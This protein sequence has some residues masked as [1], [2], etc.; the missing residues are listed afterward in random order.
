M[1]DALRRLDA[2]LARGEAA[3][4]G[5]LLVAMIVAASGQ[6]LL[7]NLTN[8]GVGWANRLL[9]GADWIDPFLQLGT[10][11]L[12]F[13]GASLAAHADRHIAID[14]LPRIAPPRGRAYMRGVALTAAGVVCFFLSNVFLEA[15]L[16][17]GS[18]RTLALE[19]LTDDG[20]AHVCDV[21]DAVLAEAGVR[22]PVGF[23]GLRAVLGAVGLPIETPGPALQL[24]APLGFLVVGLRL[25]A[26]GVD[27]LR[28]GAL[29]EAHDAAPP[30]GGHG[31]S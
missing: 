9:L 8:A 19:V 7:R 10:L 20:A 6:A 22:R 15:V 5:L 16:N 4:A 2:L 3:L 23:C 27:A 21:S 1:R 17:L 30:L 29:N 31:T 14:V 18:V 24:V 26:R 11:W 12:A 25:L 13:L 28:A